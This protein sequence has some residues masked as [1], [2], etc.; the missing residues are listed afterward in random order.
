MGY[1][2]I[3]LYYGDGKGKTTAAIGL[4]IRAAGAGKKV[5]FSQFMKGNDTAELS[6]LRNIAEVKIVRPQKMYPFFKDMT[7]E[8]KRQMKE[9]HN[10]MLL[11]IQGIVERGGAQVV[12]LDEVTYPIT[13]ELV[14]EKL[15]KKLLKSHNA[16]IVL[17]GR[18]PTKE[19]LEMSD[20]VTEMKKIKH[21]YEKGLKARKGIEY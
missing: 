13:Y 21:P 12:I 3:H 11:E 6:I 4:A 18:N 9:E 10:A 1:D 8:E 2:K 17:T 15:L 16:E 5:V 19:L 7:E 14:D 20:Y